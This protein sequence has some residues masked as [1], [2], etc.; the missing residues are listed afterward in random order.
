MCHS[1][2]PTG[3]ALKWPSHL[4]EFGDIQSSV[5]RILSVLLGLDL[6][7]S[8][9]CISSTNLKCHVIWWS[10]C[11]VL[12]IL[13]TALITADIMIFLNFW[14]FMAFELYSNLFKLELICP[15]YGLVYSYL[16]SVIFNF[17]FESKRFVLNNFYY[18]FI[19]F[20]FG[21]SDWVE[22]VFRLFPCILRWLPLL[23]L[24]I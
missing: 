4:G 23:V 9:K 2:E 11:S 7:N 3:L 8:Q 5:P 21:W 13:F 24:L 18:L 1:W 22:S 20:L 12:R 6:V 10:I 17:I 15:I 14:N 16:A 19:L